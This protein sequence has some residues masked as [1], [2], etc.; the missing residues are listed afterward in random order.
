MKKWEEYSLTAFNS[1]KANLY[2]WESSNSDTKR[3]LTR[4][5]YDQVFTSG[6]PNRTGYISISAM[7]EKLKKIEPCKEHC[8]SPQFVA[9]MIFDNPDIWLVDHEKFKS[10]FYQCCL[11]ILVT[12]EENKKLSQLTENKDGKFI[13]HV[14]THKKYEHLNIQ[15]FHPEKGIV[16]NVF[17]ELVPVE[18]IEYE[19]QYLLETADTF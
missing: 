13:V 16:D 19:K 3:S 9:R 4:L 7:Q 12:S 6:D 14:P 18:L 11:T 1:M 2:R 5:L 15:L 17:D 8:L 10:L